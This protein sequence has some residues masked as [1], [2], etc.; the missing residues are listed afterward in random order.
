MLN[1]IKNQR[2]GIIQYSLVSLTLLV[3]SA[4]FAI[5]FFS[6][7]QWIGG[8]L[9]SVLFALPCLFIVLFS[10]PM[11]F[12]KFKKNNGTNSEEKDK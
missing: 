1:T 3:I 5:K 4:F 8:I 12:S 10:L 2:G 7:G 9:V 6:T 11:I